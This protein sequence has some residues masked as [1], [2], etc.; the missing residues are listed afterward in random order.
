MLGGLASRFWRSVAICWPAFVC[1]EP[2]KM[3]LVFLLFP[4]QPA[5]TCTLNIHHAEQVHV[6][7]EAFQAGGG[8]GGGGQSFAGS[9]TA[10]PSNTFGR[11]RSNKTKDKVY[12]M[13]HTVPGC[14]IHFS[15][16]N[17]TMGSHCLLVF[18][19]ESNQSRFSYKRTLPFASSPSF[20][21]FKSL[22][23]TWGVF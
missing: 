10:R 13:F 1:R 22:N 9:S 23:P 19:G 17:E 18:A 21:C 7:R 3:V 11:N 6:V 20:L 16:R 15:P 2:F 8:G 14:K 5:K 4:L 12:L